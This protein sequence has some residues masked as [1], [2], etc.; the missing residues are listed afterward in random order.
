MP[1]VQQLA[2][3]VQRFA[4]AASHVQPCFLAQPKQPHAAAASVSPGA[5]GPQCAPPTTSSAPLLP[6]TQRISLA[7]TKSD[8]VA[9]QDGT[10]RER[11]K[12]ERRKKEEAEGAGCARQAVC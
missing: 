11:P 4:G 10:F 7:K 9:K 3:A 5:A 1:A 6:R 8:A 2:V 12:A